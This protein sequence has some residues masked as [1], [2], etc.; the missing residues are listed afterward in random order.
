ML[1]GGAPLEHVQKFLGHERSET[2]TIYAASSPE[3]IRE[4]YERAVTRAA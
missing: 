3:A 1:D 4:S 2:T